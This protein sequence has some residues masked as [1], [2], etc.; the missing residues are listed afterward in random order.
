MY[1]CRFCGSKL[2]MHKKTLE[3]KITITDPENGDVLFVLNQEDV[4]KEVYRTEIICCKCGYE[5]R[6]AV[7]S[8]APYNEEKVYNA[9]LNTEVK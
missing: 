8:F 4:K 7:I 5:K 3:N 9:Y 6:C 1:K 2:E